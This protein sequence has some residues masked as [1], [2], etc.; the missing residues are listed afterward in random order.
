[1]IAHPFAIYS[2]IW[3][4]SGVLLLF[5][6]KAGAELGWWELPASWLL[7]LA[8]APGVALAWAALWT[9]MRSR[10]RGMPGSQLRQVLGRTC[11]GQVELAAHPGAGLPAA[12][13]Q[14]GGC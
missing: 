6:A 4:F 14:R 1:M 11:E 10:G 8:M 13:P 2:L 5:A 12:P 7:G 3:V 9:N